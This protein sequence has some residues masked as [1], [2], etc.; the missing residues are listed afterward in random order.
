[1]QQNKAWQAELKAQSQYGRNQLS[2]EIEDSNGIFNRPFEDS[3]GF[4][5]THGQNNHHNTSRQFGGSGRGG[6]NGLEYGSPRLSGHMAFLKSLKQACLP[7]RLV[8]IHDE[9]VIGEIKNF[10]EVTI[11]IRIDCATEAN[12]NAYQNRVFFK[13]NL[14]EFAPIIDG[15]TFS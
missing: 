14:V 15:V 12:P 13:Q 2:A 7:V 4:F 6:D 3:N 1:M 11:S 8:T 5:N 10:D 9:V